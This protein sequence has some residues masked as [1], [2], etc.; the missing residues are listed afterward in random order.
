MIPR[1]YFFILFS[2][3]FTINTFA[4]DCS[5]LMQKFTKLT[6]AEAGAQLKINGGK[7]REG[8]EAAQKSKALSEE[9]VYPDGILRNNNLI[10]RGYI[11]LLE[12]DSAIYYAQWGTDFVERYQEELS[13]MVQMAAQFVYGVTLLETGRYREGLEV[14]KSI[15]N[16]LNTPVLLK[17]DYWDQPCMQPTIPRM[18]KFAIEQ[19]PLA[20]GH[21]YT[22]IA[23]A[24]SYLQNAEQAV[25]YHL[26]G[27]AQY[28][29]AGSTT[30]QANAYINAGSAAQAAF[31][32]SGID[33]LQSERYYQKALALLRKEPGAALQQ[34]MVHHFLGAMY[35]YGQMPFSVALSHLDSA[36][37]YMAKADSVQCFQMTRLTKSQLSTLFYTEKAALLSKMGRLQESAQLIETAGLNI[38]RALERKPDLAFTLLPTSIYH[39]LSITSV[40]N[41]NPLQAKEYFNKAWSII[42]PDIPV[43]SMPEYIKNNEQIAYDG[44]KTRLLLYARGKIAEQDYLLGNKNNPSLLAEALTYYEASIDLH[45]NK[46]NSF[47]SL[48]VSPLLEE[49]NIT[50]LNAQY[51]SLYADAFMAAYLLYNAT[52]DPVYLEKAHIISEKNKSYILR[53]NLRDL[54]QVNGV[55]DE[56]LAREA[57]LRDSVMYLQKQIALAVNRGEIEKV[58][59]HND[60]I[61]NIRKSIEQHFEQ[62]RRD[63]P[64]FYG[65]AYADEIPPLAKL[66]ETLTDD[67]TAVLSYIYYND[68]LAFVT[69]LRSRYDPLT[70][71]IK[72]LESI[73]R[74]VNDMM[75][76]ITDENS[77]ADNVAVQKYLHYAA[78]LY[79]NLIAPIALGLEKIKR[80]IIVAEGPLQ[81][82]NFELLLTQ[83]YSLLKEKVV[84][85]SKEFPYLLKKY[86][87]SYA[88]S[89]SFLVEVNDYNGNNNAQHLRYGGFE[90]NYSGGVSLSS[91][92]EVE[93]IKRNHFQQEAE[94]WRGH[95]VTKALFKEVMNKYSFDVFHF[96]GHSQLDDI[97]PLDNR[98][99]FVQNR[100]DSIY[101]DTLT[102]AELYTMRIRAKL[103]I[104]ASCDSG[105][106]SF[107]QPGEGLLSLSRGFAYAGC[108][109]MIIGQWE[110]DNTASEKI[111][112]YFFGYL[113]K[114]YLP[115]SAL[116]QAKLNYL[117]DSNLAPS[118]LSPNVWAPYQ[119]W[120][121]MQSILR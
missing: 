115:D 18:Q 33:T 19:I 61:I 43:E 36:L 67:T 55:P 85:Q 17:M 100:L 45:N 96:S 48:G 104:I 27:A 63:Y 11:Q 114:G 70:L 90:P 5:E 101:L 65:L 37:L 82:L 73:D 56:V 113:N 15:P 72:T 46:R 69:L 1:L 77:N 95:Q 39:I 64:T 8:I 102:L 78:T 40:R 108:P 38:A 121:Y 53:K 103:A 87:I 86:A 79:S 92:N 26:A 94:A 80:L 29:K 24:Y 105:N 112:D 111:M 35:E 31:F 42:H 109:G 21:T 28:S 10:V 59:Q 16:I 97:R 66:Q 44:I 62:V 32:R 34:S 93:I 71:P 75:Q 52:K 89:L 25:S 106:S 119:A 60:Q 68:T 12:Y 47:S 20:L 6:F 50:S 23:D 41:N 88:P 76:V 118:G 51:A 99:L 7:Y 57:I 81:R 116:Q 91:F 9:Y 58:S 84:E 4:Q 49:V 2:W 13:P 120:G 110:V 3:F 83:Q 30:D 98:M 117:N 54:R 14:L 107:V 22:F 74:Q